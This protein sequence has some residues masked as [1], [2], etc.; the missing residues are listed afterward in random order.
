MPETRSSTRNAKATATGEKHPLA[1]ETATAQPK[2]K[3]SKAA[4]TE[5]NSKENK[6]NLNPLERG[7]GRNATKKEPKSSVTKGGKGDDRTPSNILEKGII[8]FFIRGRVDVSK[9]ESVNEIARSYFILRPIAVDEKLG[10]GAIDDAGNARLCVL[11]K[12]V[13]PSSGND[14]FMAFVEKTGVT[15]NDLKDDFLPGNDYETKT[16][17]HRHTPAATPV[18]EGV[19]AITTTGKESHLVYILTTPSSLGEVQKKLGLRERAS[20]IVSAKN[21][22]FPAPGNARLPEGPKYPKK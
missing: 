3:K 9:P 2:S 17:G 7:T 11:P 6:A 15:L 1:G 18:G 8:Y 21:P 12:K 4:D 13:L 19:Y 16:V 14:R 22:K 20:F 10:T 5:K